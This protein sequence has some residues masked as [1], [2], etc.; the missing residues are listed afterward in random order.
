MTSLP[1]SRP[2]CPFRA[3]QSRLSSSDHARLEVFQSTNLRVDH[4]RRVLGALTAPLPPSKLPPVVVAAMSALGKLLVAE[5]VEEATRVQAAQMQQQ[6]ASGSGG[7]SGHPQA[8]KP[9]AVI[10]A[11]QNLVAA[12]R[13]P[14]TKAGVQIISTR[15]AI[16]ERFLDAI[17]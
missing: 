13:I 15:S 7:S 3:W 16:R 8:L 10:E 2:R 14:H 6:G 11:Y 5:L 1:A 9:A 4:M 17:K 12:G